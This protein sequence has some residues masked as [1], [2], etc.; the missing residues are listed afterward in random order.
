MNSLIRYAELSS[1]FILTKIFIELYFF[2]SRHVKLY[3]FYIFFYTFNNL[4]F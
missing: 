3:L 1:M 2:S 4:A